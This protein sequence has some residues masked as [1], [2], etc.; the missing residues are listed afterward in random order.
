MRTKSMFRAGWIVLGALPLLLWP[1]TAAAQ[2]LINSGQCVDA[3]SVTQGVLNAGDTNNCT[4]NDVTFVVVG[5]GTQTDGCVNT[6]D[7]VSINLQGRLHN[8]TAQ[9][10]YDLGMY[11]SKNGQSAKTG[12]DCARAILSPVATQ[13]LAMCTGAN[14]LDLARLD[15]PGNPD[16]GPY[17]NTD[18]DACGD[19]RAHDNAGCDRDPSDNVASGGDKGTW[20]D[21]VIIFTSPLTF[22]CGDGDSNGFVD[23]PTCATWGNQTEEVHSKGAGT[24]NTCD[25]ATEVVPGTKAKCNCSTLQSTIPVAKLFCS[26]TGN[27]A[28]QGQMS[29]VLHDTN[30]NNTLDPIPGEYTRCTVWYTNAVTSCTDPSPTPAERFRCGTAS[31]TFFQVDYDETRGGVSKRR[32]ERRGRHLDRQ[33]RFAG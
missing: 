19:L 31:Y 33:R 14:L 20:D 3:N 15:P 21:S 9:D 25:S 6:N 26:S 17:L 32:R 18:G 1:G 8:S 11:I 2:I 23:I 22:P 29:C 10:R 7:N 5:L 12:T 30:S 27:I 13:G 4:S 28:T 16:N 24:N